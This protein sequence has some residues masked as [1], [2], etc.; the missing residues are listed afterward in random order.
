MST[1]QQ[2]IEKRVLAA[3]FRNKDGYLYFRDATNTMYKHGRQYAKNVDLYDKLFAMNNKEYGVGMGVTTFMKNLKLDWFEM[4]F[5]DYVETRHRLTPA[6]DLRDFFENKKPTA[7]EI[8]KMFHYYMEILTLSEKGVICPLPH[9]SKEL[10]TQKE[11]PQLTHDLLRVIK[12]KGYAPMMVEVPCVL[13]GLKLMNEFGTL[14]WTSAAIDMI[15]THP[16][17][18]TCVFDYKFSAHDAPRLESVL[19]LQLI[20]LC[21]ASLG[22]EVNKMMLVHVNYVSGMA[23]FYDIPVMD[24]LLLTS[25]V[26]GKKL[27]EEVYN[28]V[29]AKQ[30]VRL[31]R[32]LVE[33]M[34]QNHYGVSAPIYVERRGKNMWCYMDEL[35]ET[36]LALPRLLV[37]NYKKLSEIPIMCGIKLR[38]TEA[39][40]KRDWTKSVAFHVLSQYAINLVKPE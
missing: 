9:D 36:C 18:G 6:E 32:P 21:C 22:I 25:I 10:Y 39:L 5:G 15:A 34:C 23:I 2:A 14:K 30:Y 24:P 4:D 27:T 38:R 16:L 7:L 13:D 28:G 12:K 29:D 20:G 33:R 31:F 37:E 8:G 26:R 17:Y 35:Q 1:I 40:H 19:Q 11:A 3:L